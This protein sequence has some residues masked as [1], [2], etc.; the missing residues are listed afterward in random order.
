[1]LGIELATTGQARCQPRER[2]PHLCRVVIDLCSRIAPCLPPQHWRKARHHQAHFARIRRTYIPSM[3]SA[4]KEFGH[5]VLLL[6]SEIA[7][8][9]LTIELTF[10]QS[11]S[12]P[13]LLEKRL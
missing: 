9:T 5:F 12:H 10:A 7:T 2:S 11:H 4:H 13:I 8:L 3:I 6:G 1:M